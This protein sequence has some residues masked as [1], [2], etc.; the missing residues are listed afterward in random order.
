M[1]INR[2]TIVRGPCMVSW[3]S[4]QFWSKGDVKL[5]VPLKIFEL[6]TSACGKVGEALADR[7]ATVPLEPAGEITAAF[8]SALWPYASFAIGASIFGA[9]DLPLIIYALDGT[10]YTFA[11]AA[12]TRMPDIIQSAKKTAVG[13]LEFTCIGKDNT[14]WSAAN[15]FLQVGSL[16]LP[17]I[18]FTPANVLYGAVSAAWGASPFDAFVCKDGFMTSFNMEIEPFDLDSD[19][20]I[21]FWLKKLD[22]TTRA[23]PVT[24]VTVP[25]ATVAI[26]AAAALAQAAAGRRRR[27]PARQPARQCQRPGDDPDGRDGA[28]RPHH[29]KGG[30]QRGPPRL[31]LRRSAHR[32]DGVGRDQG[33]HRRRREPNLRDRMTAKQKLYRRN[34]VS[35]CRRS[36]TP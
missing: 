13:P 5:S 1:P 12:L 27:R 20:T 3:N 10:S 32:R 24:N 29:Q 33:F 26:T 15:S 4:L 14:A 34:G 36:E 18:A 19:G 23:Q 30:A 25:A 16:A 28:H 6:M 31:R 8:K 21:D 7:I 35:E 2:T 9:T 11:A 17:A 22:V